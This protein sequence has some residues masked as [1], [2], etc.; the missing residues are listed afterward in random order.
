MK[1]YF[2]IIILLFTTGLNSETAQAKDDFKVSIGHLSVPL[3]HDLSESESIQIVYAKIESSKTVG[4]T[5]IFYLSGGPGNGAVRIANRFKKSG[6]LPPMVKVALNSGPLYFID[7]RGSGNSEPDLRC[8]ASKVLGEFTGGGYLDYLRQ[9]KKIAEYC[10]TKFYDFTRTMKALTSVESAHDLDLLRREINA[11]SIILFGESYGT[12]LSFSYMRYFGQRVEKAVLSLIEGPDHTFKLPSQFDKAILQIDKYRN[13]KH[14]SLV[15]PLIIDMISSF[16]E[17]KKISFDVYNPGI[18]QTEKATLSLFEFRLYLRFLSKKS[19]QPLLYKVLYEKDYLTIKQ[20]VVSWFGRGRL[21]GMFFAMDCASNASKGRLQKI[22]YQ[23]KNSL[24]AEAINFP[25][26]EVC[27]YLGLDPLPS[28]F[29]SPLK[30]DVPS[31]FFSGALDYKT[32]V[33]NAQEVAENF[34]NAILV[35]DPDGFH[36]YCNNTECLDQLRSFLKQD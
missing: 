28:E 31:M 8:N 30:S 11:D 2:L 26:P 20:W 36:S 13:K 12:H 22:E 17:D 21:N 4:K 9:T 32:P 33:S 19:H 3:F 23:N 7:Q 15:Y 18:D 14:Q 16:G 34:S 1:Q 24:L 5:P 27:Q 29:R 35:D 6:I 25:F 10:K